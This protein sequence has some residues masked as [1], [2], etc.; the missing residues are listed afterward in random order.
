M[1]SRIVNPG[2]DRDYQVHDKKTE[3][4]NIAEAGI[5][6]RR[7]SRRKAAVHH[8]GAAERQARY[9]A[10]IGIDN[11][12]NAG[13]CCPNERQPFLDS[14][15]PRL[16][17]ML[18]GPG[19][20]AVPRVVGDV[21][22][23]AGARAGRDHRSGK[24]DLVADQRTGTRRARCSG[25][26]PSCAMMT[27]FMIAFSRP[28][29]WAMR[30]TSCSSAARASAARFCQSFTA[31]EAVAIVASSDLMGATARCSDPAVAGTAA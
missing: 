21:N 9:N 29:T 18:I 25:S 16:K 6:R 20:F 19:R 10:P 27:T 24:D 12:G 13:V 5:K 7:K 4:N 28:T 3:K 14:A 22:Q 31:A 26:V 23:P 1:Q 15:D 30:S 11:R 8:A 2:Y 17:E